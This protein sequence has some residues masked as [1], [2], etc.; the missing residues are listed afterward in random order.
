MAG[1][2]FWSLALLLTFISTIRTDPPR[3]TTY[4]ETVVL[5]TPGNGNYV[6]DNKFIT[7]SDKITSISLRGCLISDVSANAFEMDVNMKELDLSDNKIRSLQDNIFVANKQL[8]YI[9]LSFNVLKELPAGLFYAI[10]NLEVLILKG[11]SFDPEKLNIFNSLNKLKFLDLSSNGFLGKNLNLSM[12]DGN[13]QLASVDF[14]GNNM[15]GTSG[16]LF[17][18]LRKLDSLYLDRCSL[19]VIPDFAVGKNLE[20][21]QLLSLTQ[22]TIRAVSDPL[23]FKN[24]VNLKVLYLS[25]NILVDIDEQ[26]LWTMTKLEK[27]YLNNNKLRDIPDLLFHN[28]PSLTDIDLSHNFINYIPFEALRLTPLKNVNLASNT[29]TY[30]EGN[31][32]VDLVSFGVGLNQFYINGNPWQCACLLETLNEIKMYKIDYN[33]SFYNGENVAC[34]TG[35]RDIRGLSCDRS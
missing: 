11:N 22:N 9:N 20:N 31:F 7:H 24:L 29:F 30:L 10:P 3:C 5:C 13:Q 12:F 26:F 2:R 32:I 34:T 19:Y 14:S 6:L 25:G 18:S 28:L 27:V 23:S 33:Q 4:E 35:N 15:V 17:D 8:I 21:L 16:K 1:K